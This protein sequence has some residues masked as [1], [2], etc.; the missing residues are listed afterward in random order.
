MLG[1]RRRLKPRSASI[2]SLCAIESR[3][4]VWRVDLRLCGM[5]SKRGVCTVDSGRGGRALWCV[6]LYLGGGDLLRLWGR[7]LR[8]MSYRGGL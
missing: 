1:R 2:L 8:R 4:G 7:G 3:R 6:L 5:E